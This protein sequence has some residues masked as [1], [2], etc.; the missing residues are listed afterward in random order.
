MT[1]LDGLLVLDKPQGPTSHDL[2]ARV[3]RILRLRRVGHAG[4]LDPMATGLLLVLLG[5]ATRLARYLL[6]SPKV[7]EGTIRLG[8][9]TD[10]DDVTGR[11]LT[12]FEGMAP[13]ERSVQEAAANLVG[14]I[15][16]RPPNVSARRVGG[17]RL[18][19]LARRGVTV[20]VPAASV[21]VFR[22]EIESS[23]GAVD[24]RFVAEVS[25]GTYLRAMARDLGEAL[26]CGGTLASL[27][28]TR[29]GPFDLAAALRLPEDDA[30]AASNAR[31]RRIPLDRLPLGPPPV[32]LATDDD[33]R[34]FLGGAP[35]GTT[36]DP[37]DGSVVVRAADGSLVGIGVVSA[38]IVRPRVV[39]APERSSGVAPACPSD[40]G[41]DNLRPFSAEK[42]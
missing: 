4:T 11:V 12:R 22:F 10:T 27:R 35:A 3:R 36:D 25:S 38:G 18:Y 29:I 26:G 5:R 20:A 33:L 9:T 14:R 37:P 40:S 23:G 1:G 15:S 19:R 32:V 31:E 39:L 17:E 30:E 28:R 34:R 41:C 8:L 7:Y 16:Q 13:G 42:G 6:D 2:V 21:E 24:W